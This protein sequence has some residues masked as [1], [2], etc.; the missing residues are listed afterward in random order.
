[1]EK[2][3]LPIGFMDSGLGGLSVL[4][5]ALRIMPYDDFI[6]Y[7]D[8]RNAPYG[9]KDQETIRRLTFQV[10]EMLLERG[11]K[12]LA[13]ACNTAT[14]AAVAKLRLA[15]PQLPI[16]GIEPAVKPAALG[17]RTGVI[18]VLA[19]AG[20]LKG[21]GKDGTHHNT[22]RADCKGFRHITG[23][24][25]AAVGDQRKLIAD[26]LAH[27]INRGDLRR[28]D[29]CNH[30]G[31]ADGP[32]TDTN[33]DSVNSRIPRLWN[34]HAPYQAQKR[35]P[36]LRR[37]AQCVFHRKARWRRQHADGAPDPGCKREHHS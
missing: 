28:A 4:K 6:Y 31:G 7:G 1:M 35:R 29:S 23:L 30:A 20:T 36:R 15:Y 25:D 21:C 10:V 32:G 37:E 14:S 26:S 2:K 8:S 17:T 33:L 9:V 19:T 34:V 11:I 27:L 12:G 5:E 13:I 3:D 24:L 22:G 18:G 16:V